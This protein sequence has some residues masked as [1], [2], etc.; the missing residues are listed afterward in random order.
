[1]TD[2]LM[3][4]SRP[5]LSHLGESPPDESEAEWFRSEAEKCR[6]MAEK[7]TKKLTEKR[8]SSSL[9]TGASCL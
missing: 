9:I 5:Q 8:G 4:R 2:G 7:A 1:M 3:F 6:H